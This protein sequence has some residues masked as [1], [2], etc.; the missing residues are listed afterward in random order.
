[1]TTI[2]EAYNYNGWTNYETW[3]ASLHQDAYHWKDRAHEIASD[4]IDEDHDICDLAS[5]THHQLAME[6]KQ[7]INGNAPDDLDGLY[8]DIM[9]AALMEINTREMAEAY[10]DGIV[11]Y[12]VG[13]NMP[14]YMPDSDPAVFLNRDDAVVS[15]SETMEEHAEELRESSG[16]DEDPTAEALETCAAGLLQYKADEYGHTLG[17]YHYFI[18]PFPLGQED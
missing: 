4:L 13:W 18:T 1:M 10:M 9:S 3:S 12:S 6:I 7:S 2:K 17:Q 5:E 14:D 8:S 16:D 15:L 11:A